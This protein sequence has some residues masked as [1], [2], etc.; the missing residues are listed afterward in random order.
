MTAIIKDPTERA[1]F[2][3]FA[4]VGAIGSVVDFGIMN[5]LVSLAHLTLVAA[6]TISF[7]SAVIS[8]FTWNRFWTYPES[9]SKPLVGQLAQFGFVNTLG[10]LIRIPILYFAEP[11]LDK[12]LGNLPIQAMARLHTFLSH[13]ITLAFAIGVVM[14]WNYFVNRYWTYND[15]DG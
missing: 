13:N 6:G 4:V 2:L 8:N 14:M 12:F 1:R 5:L 7:I 3:K 9:R 15:I 11:L 10:L